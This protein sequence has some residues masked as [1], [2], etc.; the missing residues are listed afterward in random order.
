MSDHWILDEFHQPQKVS[1]EEWAKWIS[2]PKAKI[3]K[4]ENSNGFHVSTVFLGLDHGFSSS[5]MG[6]EP[7][8]FETM[9]FGLPNESE[10]QDRCSTYQEALRMHEKAILHTMSI[11]T[12]DGMVRDDNAP[13]EEIFE[14]MKKAATTIWSTYDNTYGYVDEKMERVNNLKNVKDNAMILYR[15]FDHWNQAIM[16]EKLHINSLHYIK[17]NN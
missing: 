17:Q 3:V 11:E 1:L 6:A 9:I 15:M 4:Q 13:S 7:I 2:D 14:D 5:L 16:R 10:Y 12:D 8:L